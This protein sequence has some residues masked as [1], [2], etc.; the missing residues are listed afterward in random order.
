MAALDSCSNSPS[1]LT[2]IEAFLLKTG[3]LVP[4]ET[5]NGKP[6][7]FFLPTLLSEPEDLDWTFMSSCSMTTTLCHTWKFLEGAPQNLMEL[8]TIE[9]VKSLHRLSTSTSVQGRIR[10]HELRCWSTDMILQ[11]G[12]VDR[13]TSEETFVEARVAVVDETSAHSVASATIMNAKTQRLIICGKGEEGLHGKKLWDGGYKA[14]L[15]SVTCVMANSYSHDVTCEVACPSCLSKFHPR[16]AATWNWDC[17]CS[18]TA[19]G[20]TCISCHKGHKV[21]AFLLRGG[22]PKP[23][24][25]PGLSLPGEV[26]PQDAAPSI[27]LIAGCC[28]GSLL[29]LGS[30]FIADEENG[31]VVTAA[32]VV[33]DIHDPSA[34]SKPYTNAPGAFIAIGVVDR[35]L[36]HENAVFRYV[37]EIVTQDVRNVDAA[38]LKIT[39][40]FERDY[41]TIHQSQLKMRRIPPTSIRD[42]NLKPLTMTERFSMEECVRLAGYG[43]EGEGILPLG[44][45]VNHSVDFSRGHICKDFK[46]SDLSVVD[47]GDQRSMNYEFL[48]QKELVVTGNDAVFTGQSGGPC[49]N[50]ENK[51]VGILSRSQDQYRRHYIVPVKEIVP[52]LAKALE[53]YRPT[54]RNT[55]Q[56]RVGFAPI[57]ESATGP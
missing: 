9:I 7:A 56:R 18:G 34:V 30:G 47:T 57:Q 13:T 26:A 39:G 44:G 50:S 22:Q 38:V 29:F 28:R 27:V 52:L 1:M 36:G 54:R 42:E 8:L 14:L 12:L 53:F 35:N 5:A 17:I 51:V 16:C 33:Y 55:V 11:I 45:H 40:R 10:L 15:E 20:A 3:A 2:F 46:L 32:H 23:A 49:L 24:L 21:D 6:E 48:P 19:S 25:R 43:Q 37:A 4:L 31:L 41:R